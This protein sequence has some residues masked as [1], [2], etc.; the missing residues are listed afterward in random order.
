MRER[1]AAFLAD[2]LYR[3]Y[4][5]IRED[6]RFCPHGYI[7]TTCEICTEDRRRG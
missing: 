2:V 5:R 3:L 7:G 6:I 4:E 1:L